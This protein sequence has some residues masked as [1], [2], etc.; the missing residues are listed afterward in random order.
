MAAHRRLGRGHQGD[1]KCAYVTIKP[2]KGG[3][4]REKACG[5]GTRKNFHLDLLD[6]RGAELR[7]SIA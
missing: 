2:H 5:R 3:T 6:E 1:T 4:I 7:L